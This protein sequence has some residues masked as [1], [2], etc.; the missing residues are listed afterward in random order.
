M[1]IYNK[2][3]MDINT[4]GVLYE[5]SYEYKGPIA[6]CGGKKTQ[7]VVQET[8]P[9]APMQPYLTEIGQEAKRWYESPYPGVYQGKTVAPPTPGQQKALELAYQHVE[10]PF[11]FTGLPSIS[12]IDLS[13]IQA[14][15]GI[16]TLPDVS[17]PYLG[18]ASEPL[19]QTLAGQ[20]LTPESNPYL[21]QYAGALLG[22]IT[23]KYQETL[24]PELTRA[25]MGAGAYGG[26][27]HGIATGQLG[28]ALSREL[29]DTSTKV[30]T[31]AYEA[32]RNRMMS[33][34]GLTPQYEATRTQ[35]Q[36]ARTQAE[37][38]R[39]LVELQRAGLLTDAQLKE[40]GLQ[41]Q[42]AQI[43]AQM[44]AQQATIQQQNLLTL[45]GLAGQQQVYEQALLDEERRK[46]EAEQGMPLYKLGQYANIINTLARQGGTTIQ[47]Q[48]VYG[49]SP[50]TGALGAGLAGAG[51]AGQLGLFGAAGAAASPWLL[52][53]I[54]GG[55]LLGLL[56]S[57]R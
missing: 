31:A 5:D 28:A 15:P 14:A 24:A 44:E 43:Q 32:E 56:S 25:A 33:A 46:W 12:P 8:S 42:K 40:A 29:S 11:Q 39:A 16:T 2:I 22:D 34:M 20:Y 35:V 53:V 3:I 36:A 13:A 1:K 9:W 23:R 55:V 41:L 7:K 6:E 18:M 10:K 17:M 45:S 4:G 26:S 52:P 27:R 49:Q 57:R 19:R 54:G 50:I 38:Q 21:R 48:P 47:T 30:Y 37:Q 51:L